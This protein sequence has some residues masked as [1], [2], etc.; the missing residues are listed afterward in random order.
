MKHRLYIYI[1]IYIIHILYIYSKDS[2]T[3][4]CYH[5]MCYFALQERL[6]GGAGDEPVLEPDQGGQLVR[7]A[8]MIMIDQVPWCF[9]I[10]IYRMINHDGSENDGK[11]IIQNWGECN[12]K[13]LRWSKMKLALSGQSTYLPVIKRPSKQLVAASRGPWSPLWSAKTGW[14]RGDNMIAVWKCRAAPC[15]YAYPI[16]GYHGIPIPQPSCTL[17]GTGDEWQSQVPGVGPLSVDSPLGIFQNAVYATPRGF[18][19]KVVQLW[20][21]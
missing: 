14:F 10:Y 12:M 16:Q 4:I 20:M 2:Q 5:S 3:S 9:M 19:T 11:S 7:A 8:S 17:D 13:V 6:S 21:I 18:N 15:G 1:Y